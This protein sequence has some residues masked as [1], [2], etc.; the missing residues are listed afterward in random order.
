MIT[1][2]IDIKDRR[3]SC[4]GWITAEATRRMYLWRSRLSTGIARRH[5]PVRDLLQAA[6]P[7][8]SVSHP[9]AEGA[10]EE[11]LAEAAGKDRDADHELSDPWQTEL[12]R[13]LQILRQAPA[14]GLP[15]PGVRRLL[16]EALRRF[17]FYGIGNS[18]RI[19]YSIKASRACKDAHSAQW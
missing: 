1:C 6:G 9:H 5:R 15:V 12:Y 8:L 7:V 2:P 11:W 4:C 17:L 14:P 3:V 16:W 13:T 19:P 10:G 18:D